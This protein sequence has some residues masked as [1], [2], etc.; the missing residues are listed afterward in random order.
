MEQLFTSIPAIIASLDTPDARVEEV[1]V[2]AAWKRTAGAAINERTA[3]R[4][5]LERRLVVSVE[6]ETWRLHLE[7]LAPQIL[8]RMNTKLAGRVVTFIEFLVDPALS[9]RTKPHDDGPN[10]PIVSPALTAAADAISDPHLR[11]TFLQAASAY[12]NVRS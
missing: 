9:R 5:F 3:P 2:F 1:I 4:E 7:E 6:T 8:S 12:L 10:E 11:E